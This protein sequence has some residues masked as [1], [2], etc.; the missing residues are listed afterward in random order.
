MPCT[1]FQWLQSSSNGPPPSNPQIFNLTTNYRSHAGI[2]NCAATI[3][4]LMTRFWP[5]SVD[6]LPGEEG[7]TVGP[8]PMFF[9]DEYSAN[10]TQ[11]L[12]EDS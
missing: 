10:L 4:E 7:M 9:H 12:S 3:V 6:V 5:D 2:A 8:K 1:E 11:F